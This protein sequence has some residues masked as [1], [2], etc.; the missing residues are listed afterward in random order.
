MWLFA[1]PPGRPAHGL[2]VLDAV[3]EDRHAGAGGRSRAFLADKPGEKL[4]PA[5]ELPA[6][7]RYTAMGQFGMDVEYFVASPADAAPHAPLWRETERR[8]A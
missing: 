2:A 6:G 7:A 4:L 8:P 1:T 5:R 3:G